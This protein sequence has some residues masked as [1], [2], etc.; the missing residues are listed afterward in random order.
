MIKSHKKRISPA[1]IMIYRDLSILFNQQSNGVEA[2]DVFLL[3]IVMRTASHLRRKTSPRTQSS[4]GRW[5]PEVQWSAQGDWN[6]WNPFPVRIGVTRGVYPI[7]VISREHRIYIEYIHI[8]IYIESRIT[9][10]NIV[11]PWVESLPAQRY[12]MTSGSILSTMYSTEVFSN[13]NPR[14]FAGLGAW[15]L[16]VSLVST[17]KHHAIP[18]FWWRQLSKDQAPLVPSNMENRPY[19]Q[20]WN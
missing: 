8:Y 5:Y 2:Y 14:E 6:H 13:E 1:L 10:S 7:M 12:P 19:G 4:S 9:W 18:W 3:L 11:V 20:S 17:W 16:E 15:G